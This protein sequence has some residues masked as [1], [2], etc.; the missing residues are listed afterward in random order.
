MT[1]DEVAKSVNYRVCEK[2]CATCK[3]CHLEQD[4][5]D[6][7]TSW[8]CHAPHWVSVPEDDDIVIRDESDCFTDTSPQYVCDMWEATDISVK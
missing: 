2:C 6:A 3:H 4:E 5:W 1:Y 8:F 7:E